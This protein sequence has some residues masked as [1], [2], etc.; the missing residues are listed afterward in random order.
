[1]Y[2]LGL[3]AAG[4]KPGAALV[5]GGH[6][7]EQ[8]TRIDLQYK[9]GNGKGIHDEKT[10]RYSV[11]SQRKALGTLGRGG[12]AVQRDGGYNNKTDKQT[13]R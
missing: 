3:L 9:Y 12:G 6:T 4:P 8:P 2:G 7:H 1:M 5:G 11:S 13:D 10:V